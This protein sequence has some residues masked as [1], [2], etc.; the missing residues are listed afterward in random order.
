MARR[1]GSTTGLLSGKSKKKKYGRSK[2]SAKMSEM[3][4]RALERLSRRPTMPSMPKRSLRGYKKAPKEKAQFRAGAG[5]TAL[6]KMGGAY[7]RSADAATRGAI[8]AGRAGYKARSAASNLKGKMSGRGRSTY[9]TA[10][11]RLEDKL[12][13][14]RKKM[15]RMPDVGNFANLP[16]MV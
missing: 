1:R 13:E 10:R 8:R 7:R 5:M 9:A 11:K 12:A 15:P 14:M 16:L 4:Q 3:R 2:R 6:S